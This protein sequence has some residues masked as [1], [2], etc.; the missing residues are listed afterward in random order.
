LFKSSVVDDKFEIPPDYGW[1]V[2][3]SKVDVVEVP[4]KHLTMFDAPHVGK[5]A[6]QINKRL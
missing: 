6:A 5:L 1:G 2:V 4:G 3:S